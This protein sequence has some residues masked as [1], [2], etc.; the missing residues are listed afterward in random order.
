MRTSS[1]HV[2]VRSSQRLLARIFSTARRASIP[3]VVVVVVATVTPASLATASSSPKSR[4]NIGSS[5]RVGEKLTSLSHVYSAQLRPNGMI[6]IAKRGSTVWTSSRGSGLERVLSRASNGDVKIR[7]HRLAAHA[8]TTAKEGAPSYLTMLNNGD[9][10][11][12]TKSGVPIWQGGLNAYLSS[13]SIAPYSRGALYGGS[14]PSVVCYT[15]EASNITGSAPPSN[16]L[17]SGTNVD[18]MTGDFSTS[19]TLF[20]APALGVDLSLSLGY[21]AQLAQ[22]EVAAGSGAVPFGTGW[23]SNFSSSISQGYNSSGVPTLT[24]DQGNGSQV[25]F[26]QSADGGTST[27]CDSKYDPSTG[28]F[29]GDYPTTNKYTMSGSNYQ[30]CALASVKGQISEVAGT[31]FTYQQSGGQSIEDF[32]WN[33]QLAEVTTAAASSGSPSAGLFVL[34]GVAGGSTTTTAGGV[35]LTRQ[36]PSGVTCTIIYSSDARDIVEELNSSN[37]VTTVIDP[38]GA[39]Y[40]L[41]YSGNNLI[42]VAKP[43][44]TGTPSTTS[45]VYTTLAG[46]P[47]TSDLTQIYDPNATVA[48]PAVLN[49]GEAHSTTIAYTAAGSADPGM[50]SSIEDGTAT[51]TTYSYGQACATG[52]CLGTGDSQTTT[53]TYPLEAPCPTA[54]TGC[55]PTVASP[56]ETDQYTSGLE[57]STSLGSLTNANENETWSYAWNL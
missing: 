21:D 46:S 3:F 39:T 27:S 9:L 40:A 17:D 5:L 48:T 15:C 37:Q 18:N 52:Q 13:V 29:P 41:A 34:Y 12:V 36:C 43:N 38:S 2:S 49:A 24:V 51:A 56:V 22:N 25:T 6:T 54:T 35:T 28:Q 57:T 4:L 20:D 42:S 11:L 7:T 44:G 50:V 8:T 45:Y 32:A 19:N 23:N 1:P 30:F 31:G 26:T 33:G 47:Y 16:T 10:A 55:T 53:V 14:N